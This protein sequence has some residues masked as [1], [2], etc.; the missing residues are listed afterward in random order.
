MNIQSLVP[1]INMDTALIAA[2][3]RGATEYFFRFLH[4]LQQVLAG[5]LGQGIGAAAPATVVLAKITAGGANGSLTVVN[6]VI[7]A[8]VA[9][10]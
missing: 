2:S 8:Y 3:G 7:T 1:Q 5:T 4:G 9:P 10:T 6:G